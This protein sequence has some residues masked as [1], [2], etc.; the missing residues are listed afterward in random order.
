MSDIKKNGS[1]GQTFVIMLGGG[2][3]STRQ[4]DIHKAIELVKSLED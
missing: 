1:P 2:D 3:K 4:P